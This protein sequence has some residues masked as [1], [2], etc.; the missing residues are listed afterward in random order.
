MYPVV[1]RKDFRGSFAF[2]R[3]SRVETTRPPSKKITATSEP[4]DVSL[5]T[6]DLRCTAI[7]WRVSG[8]LKSSR[9]PGSAML[10]HASF[11]LG[12]RRARGRPALRTGD[13]LRVGRG[14]RVV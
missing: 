3:R 14:L 1:V 4:P 7:S 6:A 2:L 12:A 11:G 9:L 13:A 8:R 5:S 10:A